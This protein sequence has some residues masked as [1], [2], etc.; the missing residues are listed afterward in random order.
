M[1]NSSNRQKGATIVTVSLWLIVL[2]G[3]TALAF[4]VGRLLIIRNELQNAADAAA[5][6][7]ANCL[8]KTTAPSGTDCTRNFS[9]TMNWAIAKSKAENSIGLNK[10]DNK[11]LVDG[12][13]EPGYWNV[14]G[15]TAIQPTTL[16]PLGPCTISGGV[17]V[18]AC[19][20]PA[21]RVTV[22]RATGSNGGPVTALVSTMFGGAKIPISAS[23]V[24]V[25][26]SPSQVLP[27]AVIPIVINLCMFN[28]YWDSIKN[29]PINFEKTDVDPNHLSTVGQP[30]E[31]LIGSAY[32]YGT[33]ESGQ[34]TSFG[35]GANDVPTVRDFINNGNPDPLSIGQ[36]TYIEPGTKAS[37]YDTLANKYTGADVS[38]LVVDRPDPTGLDSKGL[39][40][41][42]AFAGFHI[43]EVNKQSKYIRGHFIQGSITN[44]S[45]GVGPAFGT[46]TPARIA[47]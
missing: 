36:D 47:K 5:L 12:V 34:W 17:M 3:L 46:Y 44:G 32:H 26:S 1:H 30:W 39:T 41:I 21:I 15:G 35:T 38:L 19:D 4:D 14:N 28:K 40:P 25:L 22:S 8:D 31:L 11:S 42:V 9:T 23:A 6:A 43:D 18:T 37:L 2:T 10:S 45:S 16:S 24:A 27:G 29:V 33:C 20:K 13:A 7:G